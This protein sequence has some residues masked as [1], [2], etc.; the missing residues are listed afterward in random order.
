MTSVTNIHHFSDGDVR[1]ASRISFGQF[2]LS[3]FVNQNQPSA[4]AFA[5]HNHA[6]TKS[7]Q[8]AKAS[9]Q[10]YDCYDIITETEAAKQLLLHKPQ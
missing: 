2:S 4:P 7:K 6:M 3:E 1:Q 10:S 9:T 5:I 8:K